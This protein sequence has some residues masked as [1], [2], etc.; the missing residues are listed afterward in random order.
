M[1]D[2]ILS[3]GETRDY[4]QIGGRQKMTQS[5]MNRMNSV[6]ILGDHSFGRR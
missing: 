3:F 1:H 5:A 6:F 4:T 2:G